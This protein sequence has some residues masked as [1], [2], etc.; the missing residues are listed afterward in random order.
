MDII[1]GLIKHKK[2]SNAERHIVKR[3]GKLTKA[4]RNKQRRRKQAEHAARVA[5]EAKAIVKQVRALYVHANVDPFP[6]D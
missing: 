4:E 3:R 1:I 2:H 6:I 5:A